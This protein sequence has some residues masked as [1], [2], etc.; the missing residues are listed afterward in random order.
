LHPQEKL[1]AAFNRIDS[2]LAIQRLIEPH[3]KHGL[4]AF[5]S[6]KI[7][8][9]DAPATIVARSDEFNSLSQFASAIRPS[10]SSPARPAA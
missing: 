6:L 9:N 4:P 7:P 8:L 1:V 5:T 2:P 3:V 10:I